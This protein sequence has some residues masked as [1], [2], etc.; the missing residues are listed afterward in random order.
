MIGVKDGL[1]RLFIRRLDSADAI[2]VPGTGGVNTAAF[3]PDGADLAF[4]AGSGSLTRLSLA[5]QQRKVV[6]TGADLTGGLMWSAAGIIF[7]R[8]GALWIVSEQGGA[9]RVL[10]VLD[11]ARHEVLHERPLVL[12]GARFVL[13]ASLTSEPD[14]ERIEAVSI[15]GGARSVVVERATTPVWSPT[16]H[17]LFAR[18]SAV[19]A[20]P[21]D[22]GTATVR[23]SAV[24][25]MRPGAMEALQS[26]DLGLWMS[27]SGTLLYLP[28][29][30]TD[31]RLVSVARDGATVALD[32][33][34]GAYANPRIAT[35]GR[36]LLIES[37]A[38]IIE[39][40][41]SDP[42]HALAADV[43]RVRHALLHVEL[44]RK[45]RRVS[46]VQPAVLGRRRR[47][48]QSAP[49]ACSD[50]QRFPFRGWAR[51]RLRA[52]RPHPARDI[53]RCVSDVDQ[54]CV[55]AQAADRDAQL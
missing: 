15:D 12:P 55:R 1:R 27:S 7:V 6:T 31:K 52:R 41:E 32:L 34:P 47:Q 5:D 53:R 9:S 39:A 30:F 33:P 46:A 26:G 54:R 37:G 8:D 25:V 35:D 18:D 40:L 44:R 10:T 29:G 13:F 2:E 48:R 16:G 50:R 51:A 4:V 23:G 38:S 43:S 45:P 3:S 36:R 28:G 42:W 22:P 49:G 11:A 20:V 19:L 21:F 24:P 17:L 14:A